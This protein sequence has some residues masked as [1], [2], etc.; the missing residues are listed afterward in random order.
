M[1]VLDRTQ[2][3]GPVP[4]GP[5]LLGVTIVAGLDDHR[6]ARPEELGHT[7][8]VVGIGGRL[9]QDAVVAQG[10]AKRSGIG[11]GRRAEPDAAAADGDRAITV[12]MAERLHVAGNGLANV[13]GDLEH[14]PGAGLL[15]GDLLDLELPS[16]LRG[17]QPSREAS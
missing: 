1:V 9:D 8:A 7:A 14:S 6:Q 15:V 4:P 17:G 3:V 2:V 5:N 13:P 16:G 11:D 10:H 12:Q